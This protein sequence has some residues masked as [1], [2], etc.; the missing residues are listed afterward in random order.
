MR[1]WAALLALALA[2]LLPPSLRAQEKVLVHEVDGRQ[3]ATMK[4]FV[5]AGSD[6]RAGL[7]FVDVEVENPDERTHD[8]EVEVGTRHWSTGNVRVTRALTLGPHERARFFLPLPSP[9]VA[10]ALV[11][12]VDGD[13]V[14]DSLGVGRRSGLVGLFVAERFD[15]QPQALM[16]LTALPSGYETRTTPQVAGC[17]PLH[18]PSDWRL[19]T[20]FD[21]VLVDGKAALAEAQQ[22]ALRRYAA[23]GGTVLVAGP[24]SLPAGPLRTLLERAGDEPIAHGFGQLLALPAFGG[25]SGSGSATAAKSRVGDL[26]PFAFG[27]LPADTGM[28][29]VQHV[30]GLGDAPVRGF[31]VIIV[32]FAIVAGPVNFALLKRRRRPLLVLL[33][34]PALGFGTT[35]LL[36]GYGL[37]QD[38]LGVRGAATSWSFL[39]QPRREGS[40]LA[41]RTLFAGLSPGT[42][43]LGND[44]VLLSER[45][46]KGHEF[47]DGWQLD[48]ASNVLDGGVLPSRTATPL[49]AVQQGPVRARLLVR[50]LADGTL[51]LLSDGGIEAEGQVVLCDLQGRWWTGQAPVLRRS[52][53]AVATAAIENLQRDAG[54]LEPPPVFGLDGMPTPSRIGRL[55][56][57]LRVLGPGGYVLRSKRAPWL[58]DHGVSVAYDKERHYV[59]GVL[60]AE[61]FVR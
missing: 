28:L 43:A 24:T 7:G 13:E 4:S 6:D 45:C 14:D 49:L 58:A 22:D 41:A 17:P 60:A 46:A 36:L 32:L 38:G 16:W 19:F 56:Q 48:A 30:P 40:A 31:L 55:E 12:R 18:L 29:Q 53:P 3:V 50:E 59:A 15:L 10:S 47:R 34:V 33:T 11:L 27:P 42:F 8:V 21:C 51:Q 57:R 5:V 39:D 26:A 52:E 37:V 1:R 2:A 61:D 23:V 54:M 25:G 35:A 44:S 9:L 20:A